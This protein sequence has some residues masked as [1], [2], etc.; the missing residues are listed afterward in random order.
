[1]KYLIVL[2]L[3][4]APFLVKADTVFGFMNGQFYDVKGTLKYA[5]LMDG[6][7]YDYSTQGMTTLSQ[8]LELST[9]TPQ[10][11]TITQGNPTPPPAP[12]IQYVFL[13]S[14]GVPQTLT[15]T[16]APVSEPVI[17]PSCNLN[18]TLDNKLTLTWSSQGIP[19]STTGSIIGT[20]T[21]NG[22]QLD[23]SHPIGNFYLSSPNGSA[24]SFNPSI[25]GWKAILG[26]VSCQLLIP[27]Q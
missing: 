18:Y 20:T 3:L 24:S 11:I 14:A 2:S 23:F 4:F 8:I 17:T 13:P 6:S 10:T 9:S 21:M 12:Q 25:F 22:G 26:D 19:T 27:F 5:C 16:P 7:C 1:M 15:P